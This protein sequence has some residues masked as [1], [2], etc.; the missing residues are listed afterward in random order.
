MRI[1]VISDIHASLRA[2]DAA[3]VAAANRELG[4]RDVCSS[5]LLEFS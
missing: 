2:L 3:S 1:G 5:L 4:F